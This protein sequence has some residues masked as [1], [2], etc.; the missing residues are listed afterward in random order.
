MENKKPGLK[1][2]IR[3]FETLSPTRQK[4]E[5][6]AGTGKKKKAGDTKAKKGRF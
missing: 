6:G 1:G 5:E 4:P 3:R 2:L